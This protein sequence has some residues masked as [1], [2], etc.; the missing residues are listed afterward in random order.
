MGAGIGRVSQGLL[1]NFFHKVSLLESNPDFLDKAKTSIDP[2]RLSQVYPIRI[3]DEFQTDE[4]FD[5]VWIQ[6]VIIYSSDAELI[7][8]LRTAAKA[9]SPGGMIGLKDN[10]LASAGDAVLFDEEDHSVCRTAKHLERLFEEAGLVLV[11]KALQKRM[12][13]GLFPVWMYM[14]RPQTNE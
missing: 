7:G 4:R 11:E 5:L 10:I 3:G 9:L 14:L 13:P 1:V 2:N 6:W 12:P 8:F